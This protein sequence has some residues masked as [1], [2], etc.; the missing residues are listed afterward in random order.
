MRVK[1]VAG[2]TAGAPALRDEVAV[3]EGVGVEARG[4]AAA[5][6]PCGLFFAELF[7]PVGRR[8]SEGDEH[9]AARLLFEPSVRRADL[10]PKVGS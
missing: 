9:V 3:S 5:P 8:L 10:V 2:H 7:P 4:H 1:A 6:D